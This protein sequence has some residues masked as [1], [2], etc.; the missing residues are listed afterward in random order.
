MD[1]DVEGSDGVFELTVYSV[2]GDWWNGGYLWLAD[3][4]GD[5]AE[6]VLTAS[7]D[8]VFVR[9]FNGAGFD[10][11]AI[12]LPASIWGGA[13]FSWGGD[14]DGDGKDELVTAI[15]GGII[16]IK[17]FASISPSAP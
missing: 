4:D 2:R 7:G 9:S 17:N 12:I 13:G 16:Y 10:E 3:I 5:G 6:E 11:R 15:S 1:T 8:N 14:I